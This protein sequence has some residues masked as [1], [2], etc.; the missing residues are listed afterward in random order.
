MADAKKSI[1][2]EKASIEQL[3]VFADIVLQIETS[4]KNT[5]QQIIGKIK[6]AGYNRD[7]IPSNLSIPSAPPVDLGPQ[8]ATAALR[9]REEEDGNV[10]YRILIPME[11]KPGGEDPVEVMVN[12]SRMAIPR[13]E[14]HKVPEK[15][16][17]ALQ[18]AKKFV[19]DEYIEGLGGLGQPRVVMSYPFSFA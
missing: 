18:N 11:D 15:Y 13:G 4:E 12:G 2:I 5:R 19:Y 1:E 8:S 16:V 7:T 14:P 3:R 10:F 9:A 6:Q 17:E